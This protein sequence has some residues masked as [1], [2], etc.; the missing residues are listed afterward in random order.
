MGVYSIG[1]DIAE[2]ERMRDMI[3]RHGNRFLNRVFT[4]REIEYC[5]PRV[6]YAQGFAARFAAKEAVFKAAGTGLIQGMRWR[7]VEV[8]NNARG[9][10]GIQLSGATAKM[11]EGRNIHLSLSHTDQVAI[12]MVVLEE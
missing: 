5:R 2:V 11:L 10:P 7:D 4:T 1:V 8:V 3:D 12:A 6:T 9:R